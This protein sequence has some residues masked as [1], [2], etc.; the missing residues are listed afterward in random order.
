MKLHSRVPTMRP[1]ALPASTIV[2]APG[3]VPWKGLVER[4]EQE[5]GDESDEREVT[6][7]LLSMRATALQAGGE[8]DLS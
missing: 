5:P 1:T 6:P 7:P 4:A 8:A 2:M 3:M